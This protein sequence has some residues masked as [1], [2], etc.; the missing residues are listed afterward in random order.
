M[1]PIVSGLEVVRSEILSRVPIRCT[2]PLAGGPTPKQSGF[3][4]PKTILRRAIMQAWALGWIRSA[5]VIR[6]IDRFHL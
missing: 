2:P 6:W 3:F 1:I 5:T 4:M